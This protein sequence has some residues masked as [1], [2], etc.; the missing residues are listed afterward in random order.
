MSQAQSSS[1]QQLK[2]NAQAA[3]SFLKQFANANRLQVLCCLVDGEKTVT[4]LVKAVGLSQSAL[5]QHL[6]KLREAELVKAQ[7]R[8]QHVY[9]RIHS[10]QAHALVSLL[11]CMFCSTPVKLATSK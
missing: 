6:A 10:M 4:E 3:E 8:G 1:F 2:R 9:Y 11:H 7:K 5:S